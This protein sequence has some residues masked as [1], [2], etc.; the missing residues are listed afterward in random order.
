MDEY[1]GIYYGDDSEK[2][3]FEGGAHFKYSKLYKRLE[4]IALEQKEKEKEKELYI[5]KKKNL[6]NLLND[7]INNFDN[8]TKEKKSRNVQSCFNNNL[9]NSTMMNNSKNKTFNSNVFFKYNQKKVNN[10][11]NNNSLMNNKSNYYLTYIKVKNKG[12]ENINSKPKS[13]AVKKGKKINISRNR[14]SFIISK[15]R[16]NTILKENGIQNIL[17][18]GKNNLLFKSMDQETKN[19][20]S[21]IEN[22]NKSSFPNYNNIINMNKYKKIR[23][24]ESY[25]ELDKIRLKTERNKNVG[26]AE[27]WNKSQN[28][29]NFIKIRLKSIN[30][31][32]GL[33]KIKKKNNIMNENKKIKE[34]SKSKLT[35]YIYK[36]IMEQ[37]NFKIG[38]ENEEKKE[39][40]IRKPNKNKNGNNA[41]KNIDV[42][43]HNNKSNINLNSQI[44]KIIYKPNINQKIDKKIIS[45]LNKLSFKGKTK[46]INTCL[47]EIN[48][49]FDIKSKKF[50]RSRNN[51]V[52]NT[53][54]SI[55]KEKF[56]TSIKTKIGKIPNI[57]QNNKI[58]Q[59]KNK[60]NKYTPISNKKINKDPIISNNNT[61]FN[62][63]N[64][65]LNYNFLLNNLPINK[66]KILNNI[67]ANNNMSELRNKPLNINIINNTCIYIKPKQSKYGIKQQSRNERTQSGMNPINY[68]QRTII[69]K[70]KPILKFAK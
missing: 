27:K 32:N 12:K 57:K 28:N 59:Q 67:N 31:N 50:L 49:S 30:S 64:K 5:H 23:T 42:L 40:I 2:K 54:R 37:F 58:I 36:N 68:T 14:I 38:K 20:K 47:N 22:L 63:N 4:Q 29:F 51:I 19:K 55:S 48:N 45:N 46:K 65:N 26:I 11:N 34:T 21:P 8:S 41:N 24:N 39:S 33:N 35:N 61:N 3:F 13:F 53:S 66:E 1:K 69:R 60:I 43:I 7:N 62:D 15:A 70:K 6:L 56:K 17:L 10:N 25:L 52:M 18:F 16:P 9:T 44:K